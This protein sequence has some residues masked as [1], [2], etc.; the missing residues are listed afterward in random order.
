MYV[1]LHAMCGISLSSPLLKKIFSQGSL[2]GLMNKMATATA[3]AANK[4]AKAAN[5]A[6]S[7]LMVTARFNEMKL[8]QVRINTKNI[9]LPPNP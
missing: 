8:H 9:G 4:L 2:G 3:D 6:D 7:D 5:E 1:E